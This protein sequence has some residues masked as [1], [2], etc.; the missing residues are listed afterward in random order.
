MP[1]EHDHRGSWLFRTRDGR[2]V[3]RGVTGSIVDRWRAVDRKS[4]TAN[5]GPAFP[6][7]TLVIPVMVF[8]VVAAP[9]LWRGRTLLALIALAFLLWVLRI[10][11][12]WQ[13]SAGALA[14]RWIR[15]GQCP[16]CG[17]TIKGLKAE[18]DGCVVCPECNGAW[19]MDAGAPL[20]LP[21]LSTRDGT[22]A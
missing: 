20:A 4:L 7:V 9:N 18:D 12:L 17:Y 22:Q 8:A 10:I 1:A 14:E 13:A 11:L 5:T 19:N 3:M 2:G 16:S 21:L 6:S 15:R